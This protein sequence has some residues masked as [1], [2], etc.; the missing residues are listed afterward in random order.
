MKTYFKNF[1]T[2]ALF[3][4][5]STYVIGF[6]C[7]PTQTQEIVGYRF[8]TILT[9]SME[10]RIPTYSIV[11]VKDIDEETTLEPEEIIT[12]HIERLGK[13]EIL[14]HHYAY[15]ETSDGVTYYRTHPETKSD[16][17]P[18]DVTQEDL[19]GTYVFH[20]PYLG[21]YVLYASSPFGMIMLGISLL[22]IAVYNYMNEHFDLEEEIELGSF[23]MQRKH[24]PDEYVTFED[25]EITMDEDY[26]YVQGAICNETSIA[27]T[28]IKI[29]FVFNDEAGNPITSYTFYGCGK[30]KLYSG[31][32]I[33]FSFMLE[34]AQDIHDYQISILSAKRS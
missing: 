28:Y 14:T 8:Y 17:D 15:S 4:M 5:L 16:L 25:I 11:C 9:D 13:D 22:I 3:L 27:L 34:Q 23:R 33:S 24:H 10:P 20:I 1:I 2:I 31:N 21:K 32:A 26:I 12:F 6:F 18:Y 19:I 30:E 29:R 7:F